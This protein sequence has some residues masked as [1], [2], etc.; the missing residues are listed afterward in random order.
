MTLGSAR[1]ADKAEIF[2]IDFAPYRNKELTLPEMATT[3]S[4]DELRAASQAS[5][6]AMLESVAG[7]DDAAAVF[8]PVDQ[9]ATDDGETGWTIAHIIVHASAGSEKG[10]FLALEQARGVPNHGRSRF[11]TDWESVTT[12][13]ACR[14]RLRESL[15]MRLASLDAWPDQPNLEISH[16]PFP[17]AGE[18]NAIARFS[19]GLAHEQGHLGQLADVVRQ[20]RTSR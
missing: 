12:I 19:L 1:R 6:D 10:A 9:A 8:V 4:K 3:I 15:R 5:V 16:E 2:V 14:Q 20:A 13:E 11:E 7:C 17:G 18:Q